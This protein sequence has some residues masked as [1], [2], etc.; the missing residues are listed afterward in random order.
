M[1]FFLGA[2]RSLICFWPFLFQPIT[3]V[4]TESCRDRRCSDSH[5]SYTRHVYCGHRLSRHWSTP[6][7]KMDVDDDDD[8]WSPPPDSD[9]ASG[10]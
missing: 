10:D 9:S 3:Q 4:K 5:G 6:P 1:G 8:N 2:L 7:V